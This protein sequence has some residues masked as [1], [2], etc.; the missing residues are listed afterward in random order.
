MDKDEW[1][2]LEI[3]APEEINEAITSAVSAA[4]HN[5]MSIS[6]TSKLQDLLNTHRDTLRIRLGNDA[7]AQVEPMRVE[8][9]P[10]STPIACS[11]RRYPPDARKFMERYANRILEYGFGEVTTEAKW[12]AAP[13]IT[14][15]P[16][17]AL[18]RFTMDYKN[19]NA[20]TE[21]I[22]WRMPHIDAE[23]VDVLGTKAFA[24]I[25]FVSG[26]WQLPLESQSQ[27]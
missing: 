19:V 25:D 12:I 8:I 9:K 21:P 26:F 16:P 13:V 15:K 24:L 11:Q 23:L 7:P 22:S 10:G 2:D 4:E 20:V 3:D 1:L 5:G 14:E 27:I 18:F 6:G 17:P